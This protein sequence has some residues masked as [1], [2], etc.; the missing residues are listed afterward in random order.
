MICPTTGDVKFDYLSKLIRL[1]YA[2][3]NVFLLVSSKTV[4]CLATFSTSLMVQMLKNLPVMW[5][6]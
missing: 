4:V 1:S 3:H 2:F 5:E 6:T